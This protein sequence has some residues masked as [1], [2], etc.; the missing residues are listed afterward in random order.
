[1]AL[2]AMRG[3]NSGTVG[4]TSDTTKPPDGVTGVAEGLIRGGISN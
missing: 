3:L 2:Y 1:M 4:G